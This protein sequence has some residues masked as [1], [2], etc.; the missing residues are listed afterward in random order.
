[1]FW[2]LVPLHDISA[3]IESKSLHTFK[4][5][6]QSYFVYA[7]KKIRKICTCLFHVYILKFH[8]P[9]YIFVYIIKVLG[10]QGL[11][12]KPQI[13]ENSL[14]DLYLQQFKPS[15]L[16]PPSM[17]NYNAQNSPQNSWATSISPTSPRR[18]LGYVVLDFRSA[19]CASRT[20]FPGLGARSHGKGHVS[21]GKV[22]NP[23]IWGLGEKQSLL[24]SVLG[25]GITLTSEPS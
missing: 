12:E 3:E 7:K 5:T 13:V 6:R 9:K 4:A 25:P 18:P 14:N 2:E 8:F 19:R 20:F 11:G 17:R 24:R 23:L 15:A 21:R 1:M 22:I 10:L 16:E